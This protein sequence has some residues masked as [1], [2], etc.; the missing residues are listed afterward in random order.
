MP[1]AGLTPTTNAGGELGYGRDVEKAAD[2]GEHRPLIGDHLHRTDDHQPARGA[3]KTADDRKWDKANSASGM[4]KSKDA[5]QQSG[6]R[7]SSSDMS[8]RVGIKRVGAALRETMNNGR[9]HGGHDDRNRAVRSGDCERQRTA[10]RHDHA[11]DGG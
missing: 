9:H 10:R 5:K 11:A 2:I 7:L 3:E 1:D 4:G 8:D 6:E